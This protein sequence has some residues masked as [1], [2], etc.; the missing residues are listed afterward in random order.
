MFHCLP[1]FFWCLSMIQLVLVDIPGL[2]IKCQLKL[3][4]CFQVEA[5]FLAFHSVSNCFSCLDGSLFPQGGYD[6]W[7]S[8]I[9]SIL[10]LNLHHQSCLKGQASP[11]QNLSWVDKYLSWDWIGHTKLLGQ[12]LDQSWFGGFVAKL[13]L[14]VFST[15]FP[16]VGFFLLLLFLDCL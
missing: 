8:G 11:W 14:N 3:L 15:D 16:V 1:P 6:A 7:T 9:L 10:I 2:L 5:Q 13:F 12:F 4:M